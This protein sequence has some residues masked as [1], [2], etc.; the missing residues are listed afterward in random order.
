[1]MGNHWIGEIANPLVA[2]WRKK[3]HRGQI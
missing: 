3:R 1:M 2:Q